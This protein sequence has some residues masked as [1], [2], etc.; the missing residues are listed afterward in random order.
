MLS[1]SRTL[2]HQGFLVF[3]CFKI[4]T[5]LHTKQTAIFND[6][7]HFSIFK[8]L[9]FKSFCRAV[10]V[11]VQGF[12]FFSSALPL[13]RKGKNLEEEWKKN[14]CWSHLMPFPPRLCSEEQVEG[15][16]ASVLD[17]TKLC[18]TLRIPH[19]F[20]LRNPVKEQ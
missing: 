17:S 14:L 18:S 10:S 2:S 16:P 6:Y 8:T 3:L 11:M 15:D 19:Q 7:K 13:S 1:K 9:E 12:Y 5:K 20:P 4:E